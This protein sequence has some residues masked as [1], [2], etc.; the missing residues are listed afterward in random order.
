[1]RAAVAI[2]LSALALSSCSDDSGDDSDTKVFK[3]DDLAISFELPTDW[4]EI[5]PDTA[6]EAAGDT[7]A[8]AEMADRVGL[9]VEQLQTLVNDQMSLVVTAPKAEDAFLANVNVIAVDSPPITASEA[10]AQFASV[11]AQEV[12]A[13]DFESSL[14]D[15]ISVSYTLG[16]L[17]SVAYGDALIFELDGQ[18]VFI[19]TTTKDPELSAELS[20]GII[21]SLESTD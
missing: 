11:G 10:E 18:Q 19:T 3:A 13:V 1:M 17:E 7:E 2:L 4:E 15:G 8:L 20:D 9:D 21:D 16:V 6:A 14:G 5:D 12:E